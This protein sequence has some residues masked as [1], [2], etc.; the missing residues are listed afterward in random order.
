MFS[1]N[2]EKGSTIIPKTADLAIFMGQSNMAGRGNYNEATITPPGHGYKF[3]SVTQPDTLFDITEP[4]GKKENNSAVND[5]RVPGI[6]RR[7]GDMVSS[8]MTSYFNKTGIPIVGVQCSRGGTSTSYWTDTK[9]KNEAQSRLTA[10]KAYLEK[11]DCKIRHTF[12]VWCQGETDGD[13]IHSGNQTIEGYKSATLKIFEYMKDVGVEDIFIVRTGHFNGNDKKRDEA[14]LAV[15]KA[16]AELASETENVYLTASF[17]D[18][19]DD[20]TDAYHYNQR[21]YNAVG[22]IVGNVIADIYLK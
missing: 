4:F 10:A 9:V 22:N 19:I 7:N 2:I 5:S 1:K 18:Y 14:Y 3:K 8:V 12:M 11:T 17:L 20:M 16:Q 6:D 21:A 13:K 15:N